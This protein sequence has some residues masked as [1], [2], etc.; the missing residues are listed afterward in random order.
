VIVAAL[1]DVDARRARTMRSST[2]SPRWLSTT[3]TSTWGRSR[4]TYAC[5]ISAVLSAMMPRPFGCW[6]T[7]PRLEKFAM[8]MTPTFSPS[9]LKTVNGL[10][11]VSSPVSFAVPLGGKT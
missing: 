11:S 9:R 6:N 10:S 8:P 4:S 3:I 2:S 1:D 7:E 5:A